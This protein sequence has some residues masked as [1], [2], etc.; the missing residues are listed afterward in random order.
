[1]QTLQRGQKIRLAEITPATK[2]QARLEFK[3]SGLVF[4]LSCFGL[5]DASQLADDRY[6]VFFNQKESPQ[7]EIVLSSLSGETAHFEIDLARLPATVRRLVFV[8]TVDGPGQMS[9]LQ[10]GR[11]VLASGGEDV[12]EFAFTGADLSSE[13]AIMVSEV[14]FKGEWRLAANGQGFKEGLN[15]VLRHFGG[16]EIEEAEPQPMPLASQKHNGAVDFAPTKVPAI[17]PVE[18]APV[19]EKPKLVRLEKANSSFKINL[20]KAAGEIIATAMWID[21]GDRRSDNDDLDLRAGILLPDGNMSI[22]TCNSPGAL[23]NK[24]FVMHEGDV[25]S[26]TRAAPGQETVKV[27]AQI[28]DKYGGDVAIVF[29]IYSAIAN[30]PVAISSLQ[31]Q[32]KLQYGEQIVECKIDFKANPDAKKKFVYTY[33]IGLALIKG[34]QIEIRPGGQVSAPASE[35]TPWLQWDDNGDVNVTMD[36]PAVVKT[37]GKLLSGLLNAGNKKKYI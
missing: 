20:Q 9:G 33:V 17:S 36:G 8:A 15:A 32:M 26:A 21:N 35:A 11:F 4:D 34:G 22:V 31:P 13:K 3:A 19:T 18:K 5:D 7:N 25:K 23:Q 16:Q 27:N 24:P 29:S 2:L 28:G 12:C 37:G 14:Y 1:M 6:F 10:T 30:G